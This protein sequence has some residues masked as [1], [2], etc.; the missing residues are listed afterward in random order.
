M[1]T[2]LFLKVFSSLFALVNPLLG[3]SMFL[4]L[5]VGLKISFIERV[6]IAFLISFTVLAILSISACCGSSILEF[7]DLKISSFEIFGGVIVGKI[8]LSMLNDRNSY[9]PEIKTGGYANNIIFPLTF[10][11]MVGPGAIS[12]IVT[13]SALLNESNDSLAVYAAIITISCI[14]FFIFISANILNKILGKKSI[15]AI[16]KILAL[17][18]GTVA[19]DLIICGI[20][21]T[22]NY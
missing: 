11:I 13:Y 4:S 18:L 14:I 3:F 20:K 1:N 10:P 16:T 8:A 17:L 21:H 12:K 15:G 7:F 9:S 19:V 22:L 5:T 6:K 2:V